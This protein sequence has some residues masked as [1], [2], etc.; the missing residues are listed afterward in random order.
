MKENSNLSGLPG[1]PGLEES[2]TF[3]PSKI[4]IEPKKV[5]D[6]KGKYK[7]SGHLQDQILK[8]TYPKDH[9]KQLSIF[10]S[11]RENTKDQ[12]IE[13]SIEITEIVEGIKLTPSQTKVIDS[14]CKLLHD[15]SQTLD[16]KLDDYYKG[17]RG[18]EVVT[19]SG[20]TKTPAPR[21]GFTLYQLT[22]EYKGGETVAGKDVQNVKEILSELDNKKFLLSYTET[23]KTTKG[24]RIENKI[25]DFRKLIH[26]LKLTKTEYS[27]K[28]IELSKKE[29]TLIV[30]N[31]I[32]NRQINSKF[33]LYPNDINKRTAIAYG[34]QNVSGITLRLR[35][36]L[37]RLQS[38]PVLPREILLERLYYLLAEKW[39]KES[40]RKKVKEYTDKALDVVINL[41]LLKSYKIIPSK[42]TGEPKIIFTINKDFE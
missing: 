39:M 15:N 11:L 7:R 38:S 34:S 21:L 24:G 33:I 3:T 18:L 32:F 14:L 29:E 6:N 22:K 27:N 19:F 17:N 13:S 23:T 4:N 5:K 37:M 35:D 2:K 9:K 1:L 42:T 40:R 28:N 8:Y 10:D 20:D 16:P 41:G 31:P 12:I 36:Y 25:E 30:L 26:I